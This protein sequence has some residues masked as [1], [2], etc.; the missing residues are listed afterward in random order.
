V[1]VAI[2]HRARE[3]LA[4][5]HPD[6]PL[7]D[8]VQPEAYVCMFDVRD[9]ASW[10]EAAQR[11]RDLPKPRWLAVAADPWRYRALMSGVARELQCCVVL[12]RP[13]EHLRAALLPLAGLV[14]VGCIGIDQPGVAHVCAPPSIALASF[15]FSEKCRTG[16]GGAHDWRSWRTD[17]GLI[18]VRD[19][20]SSLPHIN[21][22]CDHVTEWHADA[23]IVVAAPLFEHKVDHTLSAAGLLV[24]ERLT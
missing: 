8:E 9:E 14:R 17:S 16:T 5:G 20:D 10:W 18:V 7:I 4:V 19:A 13:E 1:L 23:E 2:G 6:L 11:V 12:A 3:A 15:S 21:E 24:I 22:L